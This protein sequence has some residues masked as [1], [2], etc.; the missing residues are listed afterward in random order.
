MKFGTQHHHRLEALFVLIYKFKLFTAFSFGEEGMKMRY[1]SVLGSSQGSE[2]NKILPINTNRKLSKKAN[3]TFAS[4][5]LKIV[6]FV[7][8]EIFINFVS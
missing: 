6:C 3:Q 8:R 2:I 4:F 1:L 7:R 5:T